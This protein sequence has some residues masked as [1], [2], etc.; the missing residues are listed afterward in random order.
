MQRVSLI[1]LTLSLTALVAWGCS[2]GNGPAT[3]TL[4]PAPAD[5]LD[6]DSPANPVPADTDNLGQV[7][8]GSDEPPFRPADEAEFDVPA[9]NG[10]LERGKAARYTNCEGQTL[11]VNGNDKF[12]VFDFPRLNADAANLGSPFKYGPGEEDGVEGLVTFDSASWSAAPPEGNQP[13]H[14]TLSFE[15][16]LTI[17]GED[18]GHPIAGDFTLFFNERNNCVFVQGFSQSIKG[19]A[20][21]AANI[22]FDDPL[23]LTGNAYNPAEGDRSASYYRD[24]ANGINGYLVAEVVAVEQVNNRTYYTFAIGTPNDVK[25]GKAF[26]FIWEDQL[27][28][29]EISI[30]YMNAEE[31]QTFRFFPVKR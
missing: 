7:G 5:Q 26:M 6:T 18:E 1:A 24:T 10:S 17:E 23:R 2:G 20:D 9:D 21:H 30:P 8:G 12:K 16:T 27:G 31:N 11:F 19:Y 29:S 4:T 15:G 13:G 25:Y 28:L 3:P 22:E 14:W